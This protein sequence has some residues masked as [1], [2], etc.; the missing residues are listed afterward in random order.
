MNYVTCVSLSYTLPKNLSHLEEIYIERHKEFIKF[1]EYECKCKNAQKIISKSNAIIYKNYYMSWPSKISSRNLRL[2]Q[3]IKINVTHYVYRVK[4]KRRTI[5]SDREKA[6]EKNPACFPSKNTEQ[7]RNERDL[8]MC[9]RG[10][11]KNHRAMAK[12]WKSSPEIS[13]EIGMSTLTILF[14]TVVQIWMRATGQGKEQKISNKKG[15]KMIC[16]CKGHDLIGKKLLEL[17]VLAK[18]QDRHKKIYCISTY[19]QWII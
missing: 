15:S 13:D 18:M 2:A 17:I 19:W 14:K 5:D 11:C 9:K 16:I 6:L 7:I 12:Q 3:Q 8:L 10:I 4:D 1:Q